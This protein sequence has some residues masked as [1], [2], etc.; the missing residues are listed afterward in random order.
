MTEDISLAV[1]LY[2]RKV[3]SLKSKCFCYHAYETGQQTQSLRF[4]F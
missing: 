2:W 3:S 1:K 4:S